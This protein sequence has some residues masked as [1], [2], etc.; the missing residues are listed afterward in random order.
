MSDDI[1]FRE[2]LEIEEPASIGIL[3]L[4]PIGDTLLTSPLLKRL[5]KE[6]PNAV[7]TI[8]AGSINQ[9]VATLLPGVD[10]VIS[11]RSFPRG[12]SDLLR[13]LRT[14]FD[15]LI[16]PKD[17]RS[18]TSRILSDVLRY[19]LGLFSMHNLPSF[20]NG[21]VIPPADGPHFVDSALAPLY[22]L[23]IDLPEVRRPSLSLGTT[24]SDVAGFVSPM[25]IL[26]NVSAGAR[27]RK[28]SLECWME[29]VQSA[30]VAARELRW[31]VISAPEEMEETRAW[32]V[33][34]NLQFHETPSF[35]DAIHL[36]KNADLVLTTDTSIV[37][38][39]SI[40]NTP[41][42]ALFARR[43]EN[44]ARFA[45]LS[46]VRRVVTPTGEVG[47]VQEILVEQVVSALGE[48]LD[49]IGSTDQKSEPREI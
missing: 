40:T 7:T 36:V 45:P 4:G 15:L 17:H 34:N 47:D 9:N 2:G 23:G 11:L 21:V 38:V 49:T 42:V 27:V 13:L 24:N 20:R 33:E 30:V 32:A 46:R 31:S 39:A 28:W 35:E 16:D 48:V 29:V 5:D 19:R 22:S 3:I 41:I 26:I 10:Q 18:S 6:W 44:I 1:D 25:T 12:I 37:H 14:K 8:I 43:P